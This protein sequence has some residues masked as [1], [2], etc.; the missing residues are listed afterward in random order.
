LMGLGYLPVVREFTDA[1]YGG[2]EFF[3]LPIF[4]CAGLMW[5][6]SAADL[7]SLFVSIELVSIS[8]YVQVALMRRNLGSLE[9]GVKYLILGA[10]STGFLIYGITWL[11]GST[12][13]ASLAEIGAVLQEGTAPKA[14]VYLALGLIL[15]GLGFKIGAFPF[16]IWIPDVYQGAPTPVTAFLSVASKSAGFIVLMRIL[17]PFL[18]ASDYSD[19]VTSM[20]AWASAATLLYGSFIALL[21]TNVKRLLAYSSIAN[22]GFLLL[23]FSCAPTT[24]LPDVLSPGS[25]VCFYL[26]SYLLMTMLAF[27]VVSLARTQTGGDDFESFRGLGERSP[28]LAFALLISMVSL[29][30]IPLTAGFFGKFFL[31]RLMVNSGE[32]WLLAA[33]ILAATCGFYYYLKVVRVMYFQ[34]SDKPRFPVAP[35]PKVLMVLLM[36]GIF[37]FGINPQPIVTYAQSSPADGISETAISAE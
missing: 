1:K 18:G 21:Q 26:A 23:A 24:D 32:W 22:A 34:S 36:I 25:V 9:A 15:V 4:T 6:A 37:G 35:L 8:F 13:A 16:N 30:G 10:L 3:V 20:L 29:A 11:M 33:A 2:G 19:G 28:F 27:F 5:A 14:S 17:Q 7:V 31:F 12:Q